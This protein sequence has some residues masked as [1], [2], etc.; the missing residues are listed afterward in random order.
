MTARYRLEAGPIPLHHQVYTDLRGAL[1]DG[2][3]KPGDRLPP[4]RE[5]AAR[6]GCSLITVRRAL[7]ELAREGRLDR[8]RGRGT[9]VTVPPILHDISAP[10]SFTD[11][12]RRRG[13]DP[14]TQV[15][16]SRV[17]PA[18][19]PAAAALELPVGAPIAYLERIRGASGV[20][21]L[22]EQ[23][24]LP[25]ERFP[26]LLD[27]DFARLSLFGVL[28]SDYGVTFTRVRET[29]EPV[30][31]PPREARLLGQ[32][33]R[34]PGLRLEGITYGADVPVEF[35]RTFVA[36]GRSR[37]YLETS[38]TRARSLEPID[39]APGAERAGSP[40]RG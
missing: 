23:S 39:L 21:M 9:F 22:L 27:R 2:E 33:P 10:L 5:L 14:F 35:A 4:E 24:H 7:G 17:E 18:S 37:I 20:P 26:G 28:M 8:G 40:S 13:L 12:M 31:L 30:P 32:D 34:K 15:V 11:E 16:A 3:W 25:A 19:G 1:D 29:I 38:G 36:G 6:Y